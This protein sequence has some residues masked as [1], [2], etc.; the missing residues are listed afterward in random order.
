[1]KRFV[2]GL[3]TIAITVSMANAWDTAKKIKSGN[4]QY[5]LTV[6]CDNGSAVAI[7]E[8]TY[9]GKFYTKG[10]GYNNLNNAVKKACS[11]SSKVY[12]LKNEAIVCRDRIELKELLAG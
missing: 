5:D 3:G 1:M 11:T 2:L 6:I 8:N 9:T 4:N 12:S 7:V 10:F